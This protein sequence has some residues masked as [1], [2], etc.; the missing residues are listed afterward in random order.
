MKIRFLV[1]ALLVVNIIWSQNP[2]NI[3]ATDLTAWFK[4]D[5]L[6]LGNV[7]TWTTTIPAGAGAITVTDA[8]APYPE[9]TNVPIGEV[10]NYNM[11]LEFTLNTTANLKAL[12]NTTSLDLL[13]N[14]SAGDEG[15]F[16]G[17]YYIPAASTNNHMMLYNETGNDA[18]Q[19]RNLG[20]NGR[21]AIGKSLGTST[22]ASRDWP[23]DF[24]PT[25]IS[26]QGNR[27]GVG[28]MSTFEFMFK[29]G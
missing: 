25:I 2:G 5:A 16:F 27:S 26:Y 12:Q 19:F 29:Q 9:A 8:T 14:A 22:N 15:T 1:L 23:E 13:D 18:I 28:T 21:F 11:T 24:R 17:C 4:P 7:T 3:G 10:S 20:A 6:V